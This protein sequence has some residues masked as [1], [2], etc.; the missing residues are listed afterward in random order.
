[1]SYYRYI[2]LLSNKE[3]LGDIV[4]QCINKDFDNNLNE[5][6][7][8]I[9]KDFVM[10]EIEKKVDIILKDRIKSDKII[11]ELLKQS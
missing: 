7:I 8:D 1:M 6:N 10:L 3:S 5:K 11:K 9:I 2:E 4:N